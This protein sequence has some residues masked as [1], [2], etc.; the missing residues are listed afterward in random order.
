MTVRNA[1]F[2]AASPYRPE[3]N[4]CGGKTDETTRAGIWVVHII[5]KVF[6]ELLD[7]LCYPVMIIACKIFADELLNPVVQLDF[8]SILLLSICEVLGQ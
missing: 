5:C 8:S 4:R 1:M 3:S 6:A 2:R 7:N